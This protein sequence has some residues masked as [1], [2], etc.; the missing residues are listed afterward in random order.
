MLS[1]LVLCC[2]ILPSHALWF[3][4]YPVRRMTMAIGTRGH[5]APET[6]NYDAVG[7]FDSQVRVKGTVRVRVRV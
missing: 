5:V 7:Y 3:D 6:L 1:C 4:R 2:H